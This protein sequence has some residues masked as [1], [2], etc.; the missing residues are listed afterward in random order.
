MTTL[1]R[2]TLIYTGL[3]GTQRVARPLLPEDRENADCICF[4]DRPR[5]ALDAGDWDVFFS[6]TWTTPLSIIKVLKCLPWTLG[7]HGRSIWIDANLRPRLPLLPLFEKME[8]TD[9]LCFS[10]GRRQTVGQEHAHCAR[11]R[12]DARQRLD[13]TAKRLGANGQV[14]LYGGALLRKHTCAVRDFCQRRLMEIMLGTR[15]DQISLAPLLESSGLLLTI[16]DG[17]QLSR[18]FVV[19]LHH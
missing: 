9:M 10:H 15:R 8:G 17:R 13:Y 19:H 1:A 3:F 12:K 7:D 11:V 6:P 2:K 4:S 5:A 18:H 14:L 16:L